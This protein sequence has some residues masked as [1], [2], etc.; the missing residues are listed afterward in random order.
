MEPC[1]VLCCLKDPLPGAGHIAVLHG[2]GP[3]PER[4]T[5]RDA[6]VCGVAA[7]GVFY[8]V[9]L[10]QHLYLGQVAAPGGVGKV[11]SPPATPAPPARRSG[12]SPWK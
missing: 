6:K 11:Q 4:L 2:E 8:E 9:G 3:A 5:G 1:A 12:R 7:F 10:V